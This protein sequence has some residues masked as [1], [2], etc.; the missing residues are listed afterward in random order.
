V[1][2]TIPALP[3]RFREFAL[4]L[5]DQVEQALAHVTTRQQALELLGRNEAVERYAR[6]IKADT[7]TANAITDAKLRIVAKLGALLT[8]HK[9]G[10]GKTRSSATTGFQRN[11][12]ARY[13][14]VSAHAGK[15][16][17]Y[18]ASVA[19]ENGDGPQEMS[20]AG[21]LR[22]AKGERLQAAKAAR[23]E[24]RARRAEEGAK[25]AGTLGIVHGDFRQVAKG[26]PNGSVSLIFTDPPYNR[27]SIAVYGDLAEAA[28]RLLRPGGSLLCYCGHYLLPDILA[29]MTPHLSFYWCCACVHSGR[30]AQMREYGIS[31]GWKPI[32]WFT[33]GPRPV[34]EKQQFVYDTTSGGREK[35]AHDWQQAEAEA[36]YYIGKLTAPNETVFEPFVGGGTTAAAAISLGREIIAC[37]LDAEKVAISRGRIARL[38]GGHHA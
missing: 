10:R 16:P 28:K 26:V 18:R 14:K 35:D 9:G 17:A 34:H 7:D 6:R 22:Y 32:L 11:T 3:D 37:D 12:E 13:R 5:P 33:N 4:A 38:R 23:E 31:V 24:D 19:G 27:D 30:Q 29:L 2:R 25:V 8:P 1:N 21:F 15:L 20:I 36:A